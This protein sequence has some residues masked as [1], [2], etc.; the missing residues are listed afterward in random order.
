MPDAT[1]T[2]LPWEIH[3]VAEGH[4]P[5]LIEL[6]GVIWR[7]HYPGIISPA[8]VEYML[9]RMYASD[10]LREEI[11]SQNIRYYQLR[12]DGRMAGFAS[13]GPTDQPFAYLHYSAGTNSGV[14][15]EVG[16]G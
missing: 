2:P 1:A 9:A 14:D 6:A 8:Q 15:T 12:V 5:A 13:L 3:P 7:A 16:H 10:T 4:L 11:G